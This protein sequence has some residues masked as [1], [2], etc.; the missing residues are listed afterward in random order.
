MQP[1]SSKKGIKLKFM[2]VLEGYITNSKEVTWEWVGN[3][4]DG[5]QVETTVVKEYLL[6]ATW[7]LNHSKT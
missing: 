1:F 5:V 6:N 3:M 7:I 4:I 2:F